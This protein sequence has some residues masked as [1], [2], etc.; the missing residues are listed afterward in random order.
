M[1][2]V[3][4]LILEKLD[5]IGLTMAEASLR[6]GRSHSYLQQFLKRGVPLEL[7]E[8]ERNRLA[9]LLG[10]LEK[11]LRGPSE[12]LPKREYVKSDVSVADS[13]R[14]TSKSDVAQNLIDTG[15]TLAQLY[16]D[17]DLPVYGTQ[18]GRGGLIVTSRA[19]DH[20]GRPIALSRVEEAYG[21]IITGDSM[22]PK[23]ENGDTVIVNPSLPPRIGAT[24]IFR[25][26]TDDGTSLATV[27]IL[28]K[29][30]DNTW[31]VRQLHPRKDSTLKRSE[32]DVCHVVTDIHFAL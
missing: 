18:A 17:R 4:K 25:R 19:V 5:E 31:F 29:F 1:D 24:C 23:I 12:P 8:R 30:N 11:S 27:K 16:V 26:R 3:R 10:V 7:K 9:D 15:K 22:S 14:A 13:Q 21:M 20:T 32:W 2:V 28:R 6:I